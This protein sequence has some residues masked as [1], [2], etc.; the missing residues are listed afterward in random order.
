MK[1]RVVERLLRLVKWLM[2]FLTAEGLRRL[3]D[4]LIS[5]S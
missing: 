1:K 2:S 4:L 5:I 3:I